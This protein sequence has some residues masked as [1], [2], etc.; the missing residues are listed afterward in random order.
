M[1]CLVMRR[2]RLTEKKRKMLLRA[3][4]VIGDKYSAVFLD[5]VLSDGGRPVAGV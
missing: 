2:K 3:N 5:G 4:G 1:S